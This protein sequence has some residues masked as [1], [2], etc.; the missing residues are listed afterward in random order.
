M[1]PHQLREALDPERGQVIVTRAGKPPLIV[2]YAPND[3]TL[4]VW[5][6]DADPGYGETF[7]RALTRK[8][9]NWLIA[10]PAPRGPQPRAHRS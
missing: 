5:K 9:V 7:L 4:P 1:H 2:G 10:F 3:R 8:L 6:Y